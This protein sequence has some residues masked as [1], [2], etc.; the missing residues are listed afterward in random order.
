[1]ISLFF[2][3]FIFF[4]INQIEYFDLSMLATDRV[5]EIFSI[6]GIL[7]YLE[8]ILEILTIDKKVIE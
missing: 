6:T 4:L 7:K 3:I 2:D 1:M 8:Q 5:N